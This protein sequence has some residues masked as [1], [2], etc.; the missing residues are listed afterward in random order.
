MPVNV[1]DVIKILKRARRKKVEA[2]AAE[3]ISEEMT[4]QKRRRQE[5]P[6]KKEGASTRTPD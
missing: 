1:D 5:R 3:L 4:I 2:R 6:S